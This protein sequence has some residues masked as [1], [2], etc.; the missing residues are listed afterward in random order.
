MREGWAEHEF[1]WRG[2]LPPHGIDRPQWRGEPAAGRRILLHP[3][4]GLGDTLQF[5]RYAPLL[6]ARGLSVVLEVQRPLLRLMQ[7]M[8]GVEAVIAAGEKRPEVDL[9][10]PLMS[11]P[12]ACATDLESIPAA[13][14][15]LSPPANLEKTWRARVPEQPGSAP[16]LLVGL[17]WAGNPRPEDVRTHYTDKRRSTGLAALAPLAE[18]AGMRWFS[19]QKDGATDPAAARAFDFTD[20]MPQV[21]DFAD[22]AALVSQLDLVIAVD[23]SVAHL[24][25]AL[26]KPV[27]VLSRFDGCWRWLHGRDDTPWYPSMRL[28]RQEQPGDWAPVVARVAV[29]LARLAR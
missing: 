19:L 14:P 1:R 24:A 16:G 25:G 15:Y 20:L 3:E 13:T 9:H 12:F 10:C 18:V 6:A 7:G 29:D 2:I 4:Q 23:T 22:T 27:W 17:V 26:G 5:V 21:A 28:Y 11:L 8:P